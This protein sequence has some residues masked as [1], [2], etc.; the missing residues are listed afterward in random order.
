M[1]VGVYEVKLTVAV[2]LAG[3]KRA[4]DEMG[5]PSS[6]VA[7]RICLD[8]LLGHGQA[9]RPAQHAERPVQALFLGAQEVIAPVESSPQ[10]A[11]A[12]PGAARAEQLG[13]L[14]EPAHQIGEAEGAKASRG[15]LDYERDPFQPAAQLADLPAV[16]DGT[17]VDRLGA[18][19]EQ[20]GGGVIGQRGDLKDAFAGHGQALPARRQDAAAGGCQEALGHHGGGVD[21]VLAIVENDHDRGGREQA[22]DGVEHFG[23]GRFHHPEGACH[24]SADCVFV[25]AR[26]QRRQV[27]EGRRPAGQRPQGQPRLAHAARPSQSDQAVLSQSGAELGQ[28]RLPADER[29]RGLGR[30]AQTG[31]S[32]RRRNGGVTRKGSPVG[33]AELAEQG[34]DVALNSA[35][36]YEQ[37]LGNLGVAQALAHELKYLSFPRC[38][39]QLHDRHL[40]PCPAQMVDGGD[41]RASP[42][43]ST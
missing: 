40:G 31:S 6:G 35:L 30:P 34:G 41:D 17:G 2:A 1:S 15:E 24:S 23:A 22:G 4:V 42:Y 25:C 37:A 9:E 19:Q 16:Q 3:Q 7:G 32:A 43:R 5:D 26:S 38:R 21:E 12:V 29:R 10:A 11:M 36:R 20:R 8:Q 27:R 39:G 28:L 18:L 33:P 14:V 13:G